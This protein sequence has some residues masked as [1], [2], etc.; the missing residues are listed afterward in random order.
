MF[1]RHSPCPFSQVFLIETCMLIEFVI[2]SLEKKHNLSSK[3]KGGSGEEGGKLV[4]SD[5]VDAQTG[6]S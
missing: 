1:Q 2:I 5:V 6:G 4:T 3:E